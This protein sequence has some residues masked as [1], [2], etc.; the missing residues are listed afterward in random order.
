M[1]ADD[2]K[3]AAKDG[4]EAFGRGDAEAAMERISD[5]VEW[6]VTGDSAVSGTYSGK[7]EIGG[8][9]AQL[10]GKEFKTEPSEFI[11]EGDKVVVLSDTSVGGEQARVADL[12]TYDGDGQ[13]IRFESCGGEEAQS[14]VFPK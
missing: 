1:S 10:A 5:S 6:V 3:Q 11:A 14:R 8:L 4:Y 7:E 12:L 9:W 13:L 2:N